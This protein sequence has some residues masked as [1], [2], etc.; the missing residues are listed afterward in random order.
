VKHLVDR[1]GVEH[2][3]LGSDFDGAPISK[4]IGDAAGVPRLLEALRRAG[5]T[6][7][8]VEAIAWKNWLRVLRASWRE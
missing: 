5:F 3:G 2:V 1:A 4:E 7:T 6:D 8:E